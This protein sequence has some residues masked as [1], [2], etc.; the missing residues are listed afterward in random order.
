VAPVT[1]ASE[2]RSV[3]L[4][5]VRHGQTDCARDSIYSGSGTDIPLNEVGFEQ[6]KRAARYVKAHDMQ[7]DALIASPML[8]TQQTAKALAAVVDLPIINDER[9]IE[10]NFGEWE[11]KSVAEVH[12]ANPK[13]HGVFLSDPAVPAPGG[14]SC[15]EMYERVRGFR[16]WLFDNYAGKTVLLATHS[17]PTRVLLA[18]AANLPADQMRRFAV[19]T[20]S[21]NIVEFWEDG[22]SVVHE[23]NGG[24]V[25]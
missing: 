9:I 2:P 7:I 4:I 10:I 18:L 8:R 12:K 11:G 1:D 6:V 15:V 25:F 19:D 5:V 3:K 21:V 14:E 23:S 13:N 16:D 20:A 17:G 24:K 22:G